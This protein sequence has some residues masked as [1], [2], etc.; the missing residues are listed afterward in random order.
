MAGVGYEQ[1]VA[2]VDRYADDAA[3]RRFVAVAQEFHFL[4]FQVEDEDGRDE[5]VTDEHAAF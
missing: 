3:E 4:R 1:A 5:R 2:V